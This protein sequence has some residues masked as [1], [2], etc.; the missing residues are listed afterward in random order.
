M[1]E[2]KGIRKDIFKGNMKIELYNLKN[3][4]TESKDVADQNPEI[5]SK[6]EEIMKKEH[7]PADIDRFKIKQ[8]GDV[9]SEKSK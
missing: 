9:L 5:V 7:T 3:D 6:I 1:G 4:L 8:L 2:W